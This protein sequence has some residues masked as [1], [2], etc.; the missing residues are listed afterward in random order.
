MR[1]GNRVY[2]QGVPGHFATIIDIDPTRLKSINIRL[3][4]GAEDWVYQ[5]RCI[6]LRPPEIIPLRTWSDDVGD[7]LERFVAHGTKAY[8][9]EAARRK[10]WFD[11]YDEGAALLKARP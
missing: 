7:W 11:L 8:A 10:A 1:V 2:V 5:T 6:V 3:D 9:T 4:N